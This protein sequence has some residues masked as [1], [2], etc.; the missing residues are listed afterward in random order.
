MV[1]SLLYYACAVDMTILYVLSE[2]ASHQAKPTQRK[3]ERAKQ[4]LDY[5]HTHP[6][7]KIWYWASAMVLN[8]H[9]DAFY[10][11]AANS[12]SRAGEYFSWKLT[13]NEGPYQA[14]W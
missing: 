3:M 5:M 11:S 2:I 9:S 10:L 4:L 14:K 13:Q 8:V 7:T 6:N 12:R 1:G